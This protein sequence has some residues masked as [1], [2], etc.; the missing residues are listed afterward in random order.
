M[1]NENKNQPLKI[2][3]DY[4]KAWGS[5]EFD[6]AADCL[7]ENISFEMPIN[8]YTDKQAFVEAVKFTRAVSSEIKILA[9]FGNENEALLLYDMLLNPIGNMRI[10]EHFKIKNGKITMIRHIH[11][12]AKLR[13]VG[14]GKSNS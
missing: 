11:D 3:L 1:E 9:A 14:F 2:A 13:N 12:T 10:A 4:F 5:K 7:S 6:K 8:S